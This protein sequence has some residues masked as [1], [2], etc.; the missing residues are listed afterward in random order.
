MNNNLRFH[1]VAV[2]FKDIKKAVDFFKTLGF[3]IVSEFKTQKG[4]SVFCLKKNG[5]IIEAFETFNEVEHGGAMK[6]LAFSVHNIRSA[7]KELKELGIRF[8]EE[9]TRAEDN[10]GKVFYFAYFIGPENIK[11]EL[12]HEGEEG[13]V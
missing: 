11:F 6:H 5:F 3:E 7:V 9:I 8:T 4:K 10:D 1:H 2:K 13:G 12:H